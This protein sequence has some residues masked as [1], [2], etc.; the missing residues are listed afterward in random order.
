MKIEI[1]HLIVYGYYYQPSRTS[2]DSNILNILIS[3][4]FQFFGYSS[5]HT[6]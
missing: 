5:G 1:A 6:F 3:V 2:L 4:Y